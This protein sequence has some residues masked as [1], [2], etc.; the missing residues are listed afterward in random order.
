MD[1]GQICVKIAGRDAGQAAVVVEVL[2]KGHVLLDGGTRRRKCNVRHLQPLDQTVPI[3]KGASH[4]DVEKEFKKLNLVVWNTKP[5]KAGERPRQIRKQK[6]TQEKEKT[7][8]K[9]EAKKEEKENK[10]GSNHVLK[11]EEKK[12]KNDANI[13][14]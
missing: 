3:S 9:Q 7:P 4:A 13:Q 2:D 6:A 1:I 5:K 14:K 8:E 10:E 11:G 12:V